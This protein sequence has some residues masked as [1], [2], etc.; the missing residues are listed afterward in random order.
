[1]QIKKSIIAILIFLLVGCAGIQAVPSVNTSAELKAVVL[2]DKST[3][4]ING[5]YKLELIYESERILY[6]S[7]IFIN[8]ES[9]CVIYEAFL[10]GVYVAGYLID[11]NGDGT[12]EVW[13]LEVGHKEV[14]LTQAEAQEYYDDYF[15]DFARMVSKLGVIVEET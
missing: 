8:D 7:T 15:L 9:V 14:M 5:I 4:Q 11:Q 13:Y 12:I 1:M 10:E 3:E 6:G 2:S